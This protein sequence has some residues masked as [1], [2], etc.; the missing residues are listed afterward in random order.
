MYLNF[1]KWHGCKNDF[2]V[3]WLTDQD[4]ELVLDAIKRQAAK[5]CNRDGSAIGADGILVLHT[6]RKQDLDPY[7][8]TIINSDGTT[9]SNCGNGLRC[10][11]SSV[12][13]MHRNEGNPKELPEFVEFDVAGQMKVCRFVLGASKLNRPLVSVEMGV[14]ILN[15]AVTWFGAA[16]TELTRI[17]A[18]LGFSELTRDFG[19]C[20]IGNPHIVIFHD[21]SSREMI[22]KLG[23][24]LQKCGPW[25]QQG[26]INVHVVRGKAVEEKENTTTLNF[27]GSG[28][29]DLYEAFVW[30][31]GAGETQACGS[32]AC[33]IAACAYDGGVVSRDGWVGVD[34]PGGR[35]YVRQENEG[36]MVVLAGP[37]ELVFVGNVEI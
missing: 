14:P 37:A 7:A 6:K 9:A 30:E 35:L 15:E 27:L 19:V 34:M 17:G 36:E 18:E 29:E 21:Q 20:E 11:A 16:K 26:G 28:L 1:E 5:L 10:A 22:R 31:R 25:G 23:P 3:A 4:G 33:A 24:A 2:L 12:R 13:R 32:G 8:L